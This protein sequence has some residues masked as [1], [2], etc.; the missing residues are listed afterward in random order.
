MSEGNK[1]LTLILMRDV[2]SCMLKYVYVFNT[3][4]SKVGKSNGN[5]CVKV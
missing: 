2:A 3:Q 5:I 4:I 1:K